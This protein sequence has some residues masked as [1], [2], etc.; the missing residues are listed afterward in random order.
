MVMLFNSQTVEWFFLGGII[1]EI[2][3]TSQK[4]NYCRKFEVKF[5]S[6]F[7]QNIKN[8]ELKICDTKLIVANN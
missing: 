5:G 7:L 4:F 3:T 2:D 1:E 6:I 8:V